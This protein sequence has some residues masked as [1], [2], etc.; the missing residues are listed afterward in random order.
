MTMPALVVM[1][2]AGCGK[3]SVAQAIADAIGGTLIEGDAYHSD[4]NVAKMSAGEPLTD[5]DRAGW[6]ARLAALLAEDIA[7]GR[8]PVLACSALKARYRDVLRGGAQGLGFVF[9]DLTREAAA[10]RV[11]ARPHHFM[12][13]S[14]IDS[15]FAA[16]ERPSDEACV[17]TADATLPIADIAAQ[18]V[19]WMQQMPGWPTQSADMPKA[20]S[21]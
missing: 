7:H 11:A 16:L 18:A 9:L 20:L 4:D 19:R 2:V 12:P 6:L 14:L 13:A 1:G 17:F 10:A 8:V 3:S 5:E 15:Q 21:A